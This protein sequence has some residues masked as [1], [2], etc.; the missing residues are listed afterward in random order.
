[1]TIYRRNA[2]LRLLGAAAIWGAASPVV[3]YTLGGID[4][5]SFLAYRFFIS[6]VI[7]AIILKRRRLHHKLRDNILSVSLYGFLAFTLSLSFLFLGLEKST[8]LEVTLL[9]ATG[10]LIVT[11]GGYMFFHDRI[12]KREKI[13][14]SIALVGVFLNSLYP[15][16]VSSGALMFSGNILII[17]Y[18]LCDSASG[19]WS[20]HLVKQKIPSLDITMIGFL[21]A[22]LTIIPFTFVLRG[23]AVITDVIS[24]PLSYHLGVWYM[25]L[26]SGLLAYFWVIRGQRSIEISEAWL[27][28]YTQPLFSIP[29]AVFWLKESITPSFII[30]AAIIA[31]GIVLAETKPRNHNRKQVVN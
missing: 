30:G 1:M 31:I 11:L 27:F 16:F 28:M 22:A 12:T 14:I 13:G 18:L 15:L 3:K 17:L 6:G 19:L 9:G 5:F 25:A 24:L 2:Y 8:V 29:L 4:P 10:P 20:K 23:T 26:I 7:A 21:V